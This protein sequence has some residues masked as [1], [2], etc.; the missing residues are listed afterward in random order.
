MRDNTMSENFRKGYYNLFR[1]TRK[2]AYLRSRL[3]Y[4]KQDKARQE[5]ERLRAS[6]QKTADVFS[7][8][9]LDDKINAL[10][11]EIA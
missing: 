2:A 5:L 9:W 1:F 3:D 11:T 8:A 4:L 6:V 10:E 7:R